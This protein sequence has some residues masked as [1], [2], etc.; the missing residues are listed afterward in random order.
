MAYDPAADDYHIC[1]E[2]GELQPHCN[3]YYCRLEREAIAEAEA[4]RCGETA[5]DA[6][7]QRWADASLWVDAALAEAHAKA[8]AR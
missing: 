2:L 1:A 8:G 5:L 7:A 4:L 6:E 3:G